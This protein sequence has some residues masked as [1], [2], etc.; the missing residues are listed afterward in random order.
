MAEPIFYREAGAGSP[1]LLIH[2][3][4]SEGLQTWAR[5]IESLAAH[6]RLLVPDRRGHGASP[7]EPRSYTIAGDAI[8]ALD[9]ADRA[10]ADRFHL[11]GHSYGGL[12]AIE[13]ARR[14]PERVSSL[15]LLEPP[16]LGLLP[17]NP[18]VAP[19]I[20]RGRE[21]RQLARG[22][23]AEETAAA[24]FAMLAGPAGVDRL[25]QSAEWPA[26]V[27]E[28]ERIADAESPADYPPAA[29]AE[30]RPDLPVVVYTGGRSNAGLQALAR[31]LAE[32]LPQARLVAVPTASHAVQRTGAAF[33]DRLLD[34]TTSRTDLAGR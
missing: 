12:V 1:L 5:Q 2:G 23:E 28:A 9:V 7:R 25:R 14:A 15:H 6:H 24:F 29:L 19:L 33:D 11:A 30:L 20:T 4:L 32:L 21:I 34:V 3:D 16:Y 17:D 27:H 26:I 18:A 31:R 8:D 22:W 10:G 13:V